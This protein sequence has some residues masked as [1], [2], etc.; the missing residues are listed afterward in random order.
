MKLFLIVAAF[1]GL[2][3]VGPVSAAGRSG[4]AYN[5]PIYKNNPPGK[6]LSGAYAPAD[7]LWAFLFWAIPY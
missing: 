4:K 6:Q 2:S 5:F 7:S 3:C 1:L